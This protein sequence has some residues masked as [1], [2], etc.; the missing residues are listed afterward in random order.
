MSI[1]ERAHTAQTSFTSVWNFDDAQKREIIEP[2]DHSDCRDCLKTDDSCSISG[3]SQ[4]DTKSDNVQCATAI[5]E[6]SVEDGQTNTPTVTVCVSLVV[7]GDLTS[8]SSSAPHSQK[9]LSDDTVITVDAVEPDKLNS[10]ENSARELAKNDDNSSMTQ[11]P[12]AGGH[13]KCS[14]SGQAVDC[15]Y[16]E[17]LYDKEACLVDRSEVDDGSDCLAES[18][19]HTVSQQWCKDDGMLDSEESAN[20]AVD[21]PGAVSAV[22]ETVVETLVSG[23]AECQD[24]AWVDENVSCD[25]QEILTRAVRQ[26]VLDLGE[27]V[28]QL[29]ADSRLL[30]TDQKAGDPSCDE[31]SQ[32]LNVRTQRDSTNLDKDNKKLT[33][34][35]EDADCRAH[36]DTVSPVDVHNVVPD[37]HSAK[38][39]LSDIANNIENLQSW[40]RNANSDVQASI[41]RDGARISLS[42]VERYAGEM[43]EKKL[44]L[45]EFDAQIKELEKFDKNVVCDERY[46]LVSV[47]AQLHSFSATLNSVASE[48]VRIYTVSQKS[49]HL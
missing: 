37:R 6:S 17:Q 10:V 24:V 8:S 19:R 21:E 32:D 43:Q 4:N 38:K 49:S 46:R 48:A 33:N 45:D 11:E 26:R 9:A 1:A 40:I 27:N 22:A 34:S 18:K 5:G 12:V 42:V 25:R 23:V 29:N 47:H 16:L 2:V 31:C 41:A 30:K 7:N 20:S 28:L 39:P 3:D 35:S 36:V 15:S 14:G 13:A 44:V